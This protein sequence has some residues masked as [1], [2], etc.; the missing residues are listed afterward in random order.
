M[1]S[2]R[3]G[4]DR[5]G[6]QLQLIRAYIRIKFLSF[7]NR[8]A[9][10]KPDFWNVRCSANPCI[11]PFIIWKVSNPGLIAVC[12]VQW[13]QLWPSVYQWL[14]ARTRKTGLTWGDKGRFPFNQN[15]RKFGNSGKW[16]RNVPQKFPEIPKAVE[17]PNA[18]PST[19][20]SRNPGSKV[21]WK[22]NFQEKN[23]VYL[24]RL[25][26]FLEILENAVPFATESSKKYKADVLVEWEAP[27]ID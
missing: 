19:E 9:K 12:L 4:Q 17:F 8:I 11:L 3:D 1:A 7:E 21:E 16:Y 13:A 27:K 20:N 18:N 15:F 26:S 23:W 14:D 25:S 10:A 6:A 24:A 5:C 2:S 22:E